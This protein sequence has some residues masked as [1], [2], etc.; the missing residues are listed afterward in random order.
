[1]SSYVLVGWEVFDEEEG[2]EL[3]HHLGDHKQ[4]DKSVRTAD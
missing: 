1:M 2:V 3:L 4:R